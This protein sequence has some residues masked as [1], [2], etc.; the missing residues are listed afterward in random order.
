[1][2]ERDELILAYWERMP[3]VEEIRRTFSNPQ[4]VPD[5]KPLPKPCKDCAVVEGFYAPYAAMLSKLTPEEIEAQSRRWYCHN[6]C[7]RACAGNIEFQARIASLSL[8][9]RTYIPNIKS[10]DR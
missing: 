7:G 1:M 8:A 9:Q 10:V 4:G 6:N 2:V 3:S 5:L